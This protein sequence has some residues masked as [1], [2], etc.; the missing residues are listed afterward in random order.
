MLHFLCDSG[1]DVTFYSFENMWEYTW[2]KE[3]EAAFKSE[4]PTIRRVCDPWTASLGLAT[5]FKNNA[6]TLFP[7]AARFLVALSL[8]RAAPNWRNLLKSG[9][10]DKILVNYT[11]HSTLLNGVPL[12]HCIIDTHDLEFRELSLAR[13]R[14][15]WHWD[16]VRRMR[17]ELA[18]LDAAG[19]VIAIADTERIILETLLTNRSVIYLP[20]RFPPRPLAINP[21]AQFELLFVGAL[22]QKNEKGINAF[23]KS[24][25]GWRRRPS[26]AIAGRVCESL[27]VPETLTDSVKVLG[28]VPDIGALYQNSKIAIAPVEGTGVNMKILEALSYGRPVLAHPSAIAALPPGS[29]QCVFELGE[30][31]VIGLLSDS[32]ALASASAAAIG[33]A[34]FTQ[35]NDGWEKLSLMLSKNE[36]SAYPFQYAS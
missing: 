33:Y 2:T 11:L 7:A 24:V 28:H 14:P 20:P 4:F 32:V 1:F 23:L 27:Q 9:Q 34:D 30:D 35:K 26:I 13:R 6:L 16:T 15:I 8:A 29:G 19:A 10:Y 5:R 22:N 21:D 36:G 3:G 17:R 25:P 12:E 31:A 18:I